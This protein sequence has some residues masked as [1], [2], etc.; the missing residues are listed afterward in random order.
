MYM[1]FKI[2]R[3][4]EPQLKS[5]MLELHLFLCMTYIEKNACVVE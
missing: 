2:V 1:Y 3:T 4:E 5:E